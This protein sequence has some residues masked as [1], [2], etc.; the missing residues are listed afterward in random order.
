M[1]STNTT[2]RTIRSNTDFDIQFVDATSAQGEPCDICQDEHAYCVADVDITTEVCRFEGEYRETIPACWDC[3]P[4][5]LEGHV[6]DESAAAVE[7]PEEMRP[8]V[9]IGSR[10]LAAA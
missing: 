6:G 4:A 9:T 5:V 7:L 1:T 8:H 10:R 3:I 2:T